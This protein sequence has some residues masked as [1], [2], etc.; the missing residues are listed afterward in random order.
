MIVVTKVEM[1]KHD[2]PTMNYSTW[3]QSIPFGDFNSVEDYEK[4][5]K[6]ERAV[7]VGRKF[8]NARGEKVVLAFSPQVEE[9]LGLPFETFESMRRDVIEARRNEAKAIKAAE[10]IINADFI[11][12][13]ALAFMSLW[14]S[15]K[16][17]IQKGTSD[18]E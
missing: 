5:L 11:Q 9:T 17:M 3:E 8:V 12:L 2:R 10:T 4:D 15:V 7:L 6:V 16:Q 14:R 18:G 13:Q 1:V